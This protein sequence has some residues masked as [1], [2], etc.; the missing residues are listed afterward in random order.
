MIKIILFIFILINFYSNTHASIKEDIIS[1]FEIILLFIEALTQE[2]K[3]KLNKIII[4][5]IFFIF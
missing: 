2:I 3:K 1:N 5:I 4:L